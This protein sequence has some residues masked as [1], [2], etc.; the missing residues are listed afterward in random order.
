MRATEFSDSA[1]DSEEEMSSHTL[2]AP[3]ESDDTTSESGEDDS[4]VELPPSKLAQ[5]PVE[6]RNRVLMLTTRGVSHRCDASL[7]VLELC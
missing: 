2:S 3:E 5:L 6:L 4:K 7:K 1:S